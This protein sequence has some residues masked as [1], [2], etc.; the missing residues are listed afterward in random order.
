MVS[1][2][3]GRNEY[4]VGHRQ[5]RMHAYRAGLA[6]G[7]R[8]QSNGPRDR[9]AR[10]RQLI[11][12]VGVEAREQ[13]LQTGVLGIVAGL[14]QRAHRV[15]QELVRQRLRKV[16]DDGLGSFAAGQLLQCPVELTA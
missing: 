5:A 6:G 9:S 15:V 1:W 4:W 16:L 3:R 10:G 12:G 14:A 2:H 11:V 8:P 7:S 13:R